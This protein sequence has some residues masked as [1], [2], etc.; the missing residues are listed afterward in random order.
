MSKVNW[1]DP[2]F[3]RLLYIDDSTNVNKIKYDIVTRTMDVEF[4]NAKTYRYF[5]VAPAKFGTLCGADSVG[6]AFDKIKPMLGPYKEI[7]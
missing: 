7:K 6:S 1:E 4:K 5:C 3:T 2:Q